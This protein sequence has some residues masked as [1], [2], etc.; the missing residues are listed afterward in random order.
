MK[1][2]AALENMMPRQITKTTKVTLSH[3]MVAFGVISSN[4]RIFPAAAIGSLPARP[5]LALRQLG[6]AVTK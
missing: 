3:K 1:S 6:E 2:R 4:C 5:L